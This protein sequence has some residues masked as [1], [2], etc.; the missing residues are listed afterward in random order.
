MNVL[1]VVEQS[2]K[3]IESRF[4]YSKQ[5][6]DIL[7][8]N[9][10]D[11]MA[12]LD[13]RRK[14]DFDENSFEQLKQFVQTRPFTDYEEGALV[15]RMYNYFSE[16]YR[17]LNIKNTLAQTFYRIN[18]IKMQIDSNEFSINYAMQS[19][20]VKKYEIEMLMG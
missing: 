7:F 12:M 11:L 6:F 4:V 2:N 13:D 10:D 5:D 3:A 19:I 9:K 1:A 8:W 16:L 15:S 18:E 17:L 20:S 14:L